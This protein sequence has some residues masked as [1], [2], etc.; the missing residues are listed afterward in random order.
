[1]RDAVQ[2]G[3]EFRAEQFGRLLRLGGRAI[4]N[5][6]GSAPICSKARG[7]SD[8][9]SGRRGQPPAAP[10]VLL[11]GFMDGPSPLI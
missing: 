1:M 11:L 5:G 2:L 10:N 7:L 8:K 4:K 3:P 9:M 6:L